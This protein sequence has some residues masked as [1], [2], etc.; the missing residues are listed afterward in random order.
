MIVI[1]RNQISQ[2]LILHTGETTLSKFQ[3]SLGKY[4]HGLVLQ[5]RNSS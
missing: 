1:V 3:F 4:H 2:Y 5:I